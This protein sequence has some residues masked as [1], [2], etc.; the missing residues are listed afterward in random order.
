MNKLR[1]IRKLINSYFKG[2]IMNDNLIIDNFPSIIHF[3]SKNIENI[4]NHSANI[5]EEK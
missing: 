2:C 4:Q 3:G 5:K 1:S